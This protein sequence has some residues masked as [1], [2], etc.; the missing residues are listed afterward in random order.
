MLAMALLIASGIAAGI[1]AEVGAVAALPGEPHAVAAAGVTRDESPIPT[2][3]NPNAFDFSNTKRRVVLIGAPSGDGRAVVDAVR[4]FK[5][6]A[7]REVRARW[8]LSALPLA[9]FDDADK[10]SLP[11]WVGFQAPDL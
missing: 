11:R 1:A 9:R 4:W 2:I 6:R 3:E 7:P 10:L 8:S 5:T